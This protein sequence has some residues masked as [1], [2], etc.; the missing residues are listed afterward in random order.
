MVSRLSNWGAVGGLG[1]VFRVRVCVRGG[2]QGPRPAMAPGRDAGAKDDNSLS[3]APHCVA[4]GGHPHRV[5]IGDL[6]S[7]EQSLGGN[8]TSADSPI[9]IEF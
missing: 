6:P 7:L 5:L 4:A 2:G 9:K 8:Q 1:S 3:E